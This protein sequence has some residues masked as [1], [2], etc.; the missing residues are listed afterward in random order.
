MG[1]IQGHL[2]PYEE[3]P[4]QGESER[5]M[6]PHKEPALRYLQRTNNIDLAEMLGLEPKGEN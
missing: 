3:P 2:T 6:E 1:H 5:E 4:L